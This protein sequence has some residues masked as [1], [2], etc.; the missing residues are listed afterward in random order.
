MRHKPGRVDRGVRPYELTPTKN[1]SH[2]R[3]HERRKNS[4]FHSRLSLIRP[5]TQVTWRASASLTL[6]DALSAPLCRAAC[7]RWPPL[8]WQSCGTYSFRSTRYEITIIIAVFPPLVKARQRE[9]S[10]Q[11]SSGFFLRNK[12]TA[13]M[14]KNVTT[15][16]S[17][18]RFA[19]WVIQILYIS[20]LIWF[21][22]RMATPAANITNKKL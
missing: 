14:A 21:T 8:S 20:I 7:S 4:R 9:V 16:K 11:F 17:I 19:A 1:A 6:P 15:G 2:A 5:M 22:M 10:G 3:R 12:W 13:A 18:M